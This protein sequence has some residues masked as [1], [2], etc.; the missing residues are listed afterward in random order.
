MGDGCCTQ[1]YVRTDRV[2]AIYLLGEGSV[3]DGDDA[4]IYIILNNQFLD[5]CVCVC[6]G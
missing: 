2:I 4:V 6:V 1:S 5:M 3:K